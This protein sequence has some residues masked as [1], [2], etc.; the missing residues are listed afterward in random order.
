M[1]DHGRQLQV[2]L[3]LHGEADV[4]DPGPDGLLR[5][6]LRCPPHDDV[7]PP[8]LCEV[9][10][11]VP[12]DEP[13]EPL[14]EVN[15]VELGPQVLQSVG[16]RRAGQSHH[17][18]E[19]RRHR[20]HRLEAEALRRLEAR[21]F[22]DDQHVERRLTV[23]VVH[24][25]GE[26]VTA[27]DVDVRILAECLHPLLLGAHHPRHP[28]VPEMVPLGCLVCPCGLRHLLGCDHQCPRDL[29]PVHQ[30]AGGGE[31][32]HA[33]AESHVEE[34]AAPLV[35][36]HPPDGSLLVFIRRKSH[37]PPSVRPTY[38]QLHPCRQ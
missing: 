6:L 13:A 23:I 30:L 29:A 27:D 3:G 22:V 36:S 17:T 19:H 10:L 2:V 16:R 18:G 26:G 21:Q 15:A 37:A 20:P 34:Q 12:G 38:C 33:L 24:E 7:V 32:A 8:V 11:A 31:G 25:P 4:G 5:S 9:S 14:T 28:E 1:R 35:L